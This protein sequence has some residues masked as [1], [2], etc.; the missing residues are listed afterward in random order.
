MVYYK[1]NLLDLSGKNVS[2]YAFGSFVSLKDDVYRPPERYI[3]EDKSNGTEIVITAEEIIEG[4]GGKF[5]NIGIY[6]EDG[7]KAF[8]RICEKKMEELKSKNETQKDVDR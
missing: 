5:Y 1:Q 6:H 4:Y 2:E 7:Y 8:K 3:I